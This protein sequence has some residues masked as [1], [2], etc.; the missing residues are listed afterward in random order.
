MMAIIKIVLS[1]IIL[2]VG[3]IFFTL[4]RND[5]NLFQAPG[6]NDRLKIFLTTNSAATADNHQLKELRTPVY[7]LNAEDLYNR[8]IYAASELG[9]G[10][11]AHDSDN[12]N[13]NFVARS[14][15]FL[16]EDD[17]F[18]QVQSIDENKSSLYIQSNSR[19]GVADF[20]SNSGNIQELVKQIKK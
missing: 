6:F 17:V 8:A 20:A 16:F 4:F 5:A 1:I 19:G 11:V 14:P 3:I 18:V 15:I 10:I 9:W 7:D 13:A 12:Y 2:V